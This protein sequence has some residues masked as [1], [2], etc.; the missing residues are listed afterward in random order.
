MGLVRILT[1]VEYSF[2]QWMSAYPDSGHSSDK[3]RFYTFARTICRYNATKWHNREYVRQRILKRKPHFDPEYLEYFLR[4][5]GE[6]IQ[7]SKAYPIPCGLQFSDRG[8]KDQHVLEISVK[9]DKLEMKEKPLQ[10]HN[11]AMQPTDEAGG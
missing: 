7:Y 10:S 3:D 5:L 4:L 8:V 1:P 2:H 9:N 11:K 6:L